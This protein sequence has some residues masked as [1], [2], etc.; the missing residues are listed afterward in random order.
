MLFVL[1]L[2][3]MRAR[4][5]DTIDIASNPS[6]FGSHRQA[7]L[8]GMT[9]DKDKNLSTF[10]RSKEGLLSEPARFSPFLWISEKDVL[11][12]LCLEYKLEE[13]KGDNVYKFLVK[14]ESWTSLKKL[15]CLLYTSPSPRD[16][17]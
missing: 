2:K 6:L 14:V 1:N 3:R 16:R 13:L 15:S 12:G 10:R 4:L 11:R 9:S 8:V 7:G 5:D 17:G